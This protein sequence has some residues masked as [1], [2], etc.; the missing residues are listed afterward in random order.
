MKKYSFSHN[1]KEYFI[2]VGAIILVHTIG[3]KSIGDMPSKMIR[4]I[5][6][7][8]Y[9]HSA[10]VVECAGELYIIEAEI[11]GF[12]PDKKFSDYL[13]ALGIDREIA[14]ML[15]K[16]ELGY[17]EL[18][19][20]KSI[21]K[22]MNAPYGFWTLFIIQLIYQLTGRWYGHTEEYAEAR[23]I[24]SQTLSFIYRRVCKYWWT[25]SPKDLWNLRNTG[26]FEISFE[27]NAQARIEFESKK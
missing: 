15:P 9:N 2:Q 6:R 26:G 19:V 4:K 5:T 10:T 23:P 8:Y 21:Q 17:N 27:S 25:Y 3:S 22:I 16:E 7:C 11:R 1:G 13:N 14:I 12:N 18:E 24:C 20:N